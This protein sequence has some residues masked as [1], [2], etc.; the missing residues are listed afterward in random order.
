MKLKTGMVGLLLALLVAGCANSRG[1]GISQ[2]LG[3]LGGAALG[4]FLGSRLGSGTGQLALT[5]AG[6]L[7][8]GLLGSEAGRSLDE[9]DRRRARQAAA[10]ARTAPIGQAIQWNNPDSGNFGSV[11]PTRNGIKA[12]G[13]YCREYQQSITIGGETENGYGVACRQADGSWEIQ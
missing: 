11:T 3:G 12:D 7:I 13:R 8:G 5:A 6:A 10:R 9:V 4:G 2:T 1:P